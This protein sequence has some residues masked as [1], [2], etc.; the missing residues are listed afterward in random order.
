MKANYTNRKI[1]CLLDSDAI[2]ERDDIQRIMK[3]HKNQYR[4]I[5]IESG[6]FEDIFDLDLSIEIINELYPDGELICSSD[7]NKSKDFLSNINRLMY[8][9]KKAQFDKVL[10]AKTISLKMDIEKIPK[11]IQDIFDIASDFT[12]PTKYL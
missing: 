1:I 9:K 3:D 4:L 10:F 5:F 2:K 7:F 8:T 12:K 11:E 6:T